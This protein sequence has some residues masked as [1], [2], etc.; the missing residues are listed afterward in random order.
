ME[1]H[2]LQ[3]IPP[4]YFMKSHAVMLVYDPGESNTLRA[5]PEWMKAIQE[6]NVQNVVFSLWRND[7][8]NDLDIE[9]ETEK[10]FL[11]QNKIKKHLYFQVS[12]TLQENICESFETLVHAAHKEHHAAPR[13]NSSSI[14]V[15]SL[16]ASVSDKPR[17]HDQCCKTCC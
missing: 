1:T 9:E 11:Q 6:C 15:L 2:G 14:E 7:M 3:N 16:E 10:E 13:P 5:L 8:G 17:H 12:T 4:A